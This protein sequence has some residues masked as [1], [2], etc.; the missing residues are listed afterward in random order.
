MQVRQGGKWGAQAGRWH[1]LASLS[2]PRSLAAA[3]LVLQVEGR[4]PAGEVPATCWPI[5]LWL[6]LSLKIQLPGSCTAGG[7]RR[8]PSS[9]WPPAS[10]FTRPTPRVRSAC[11]AV[12]ACPA[13]VGRRP[14]NKLG[15]GLAG[16][17]PSSC[18]LCPASPC[19]S[20]AQQPH[21]PFAPHLP[22]STQQATPC[23]TCRACP[24]TMPGIFHP[25]I[26][27]FIPAG[28][29]VRYVSRVPVHQDGSCNGL[30]HYAALG[31]DLTGGYAVNLCPSDKPQVRG[32]CVCCS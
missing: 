23:A 11:C 1:A 30:Q 27:S 29:P 22:Y 9:S 5:P 2:S 3:A 16:L 15:S 19:P 28:D 32:S 10:R 18:E 25:S 24:C 26:H 14:L 17:H 12:G 6:R 8:T 20:P 4:A 31:R 7:R 21:R 13:N